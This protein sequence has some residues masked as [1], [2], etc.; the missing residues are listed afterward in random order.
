MTRLLGTPP[1]EDFITAFNAGDLQ[2][3]WQKGDTEKYQVK[4]QHKCKLYLGQSH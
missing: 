2:L 1:S 3:S 4:T